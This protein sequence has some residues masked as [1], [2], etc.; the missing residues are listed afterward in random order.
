MAMIQGNSIVL[1]LI[2]LVYW[3]ALFIVGI[4]GHMGDHANENKFCYF[5]FLSNWVDSGYNNE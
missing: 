1:K 5:Y 4:I 2:F 3:L